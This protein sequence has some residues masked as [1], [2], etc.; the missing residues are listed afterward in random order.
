MRKAPFLI[1]I[2]II[3]SSSETVHSMQRFSAFAKKSIELTSP[4]AKTAYDLCKNHTRLLGY[5]GLTVCGF[6]TTY[7]LARS[8]K[9]HAFVHN[10][11]E[12]IAHQLLHAG[13]TNTLEWSMAHGADINEQHN[14][15]TA[16]HHAALQG[17]TDHIESLIARGARIE[18]LDAAGEQA[19]HYAAQKGYITSIEKLLQAGASIHMALWSAA[20]TGQLETV[21]WL[22]QHGADH[23]R[24]NIGG[25]T[26]L[27]IAEFSNQQEVLHYLQSLHPLQTHGENDMR[28]HFTE[29]LDQAIARRS[30]IQA[31]IA[32]KSGASLVK[33]DE[34]QSP[35]R[36]AIARTGTAEDSAQAHEIIQ[37]L[38]EAGAPL[39][40]ADEDGCTPLHMAAGL[41]RLPVARLLLQHG[42]DAHARNSHNITALD[43]ALENHNEDMQSL[44]A[45]HMAA[46]EVRAVYQRHAQFAEIPA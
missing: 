9:I 5:T 33:T 41:E 23:R 6:A 37:A 16:L 43:I 44:L 14:G 36:Q 35:L 2:C 39:R 1:T 31:N 15:Q 29:L 32:L 21:K 4:F 12:R 27:H 38:L 17:N 34:S 8:A 42:A 26:A 11:Q 19:V 30:I 46:E 40:T 45:T 10:Q 3:F 20:Q 28:I 7:R 18:T 24:K 13:Y 25:L 22:I